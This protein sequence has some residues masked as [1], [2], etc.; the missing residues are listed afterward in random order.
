MFTDATKRIYAKMTSKI[1]EAIK[2]TGYPV[3]IILSNDKPEDGIQFRENIWGCVASMLAA[4]ASKGKTAFFD[5]KS[6]GCIGGGVALGFGNTYEGF[7]IEH[8]LSNGK[9]DFVDGTRRTKKLEEGEHYRKTPELAKQFV[10]CLPMRNVKETYVVFKPL[11]QVTDEKVESIVLFVNPDQLSALVV[12]ANYGRA[13]IDNVI[14]PWAAACQTILFAFEEN[15]KEK[16]HAI[17]GYFDLA[18][19]KHVDKN[20]LSFTIP[21]KMFLEMESNVEGS[22]LEM[23]EWKELRKR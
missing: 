22:F 3:A 20:L 19:R 10:A 12:L 15:E 16:P 6:Y 9:K 5:R 2:L 13:K 11:E 8:L 17:I 18:A 21:Y 7:P 14:A 4:S 1:A 23:E